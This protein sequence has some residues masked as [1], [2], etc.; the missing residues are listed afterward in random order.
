MKGFVGGCLFLGTSVESGF[1]PSLL[2]GCSRIPLYV[3]LLRVLPI[4]CLLIRLHEQALVVF[5]RLKCV[6]C[7][8]SEKRSQALLGSNLTRDIRTPVRQ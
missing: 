7:S 5:R 2:K 1:R 6:Y 8:R 4:A 3:E